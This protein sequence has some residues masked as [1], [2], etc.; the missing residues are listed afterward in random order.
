MGPPKLRHKKLNL[1]PNVKMILRKLGEKCY[2]MHADNFFGCSFGSNEC[3]LE[4]TSRDYSVQ[5]PTSG[6]YSQCVVGRPVLKDIRGIGAH[7]KFCSSRQFY[8]SLI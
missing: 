8:L 3:D 2:H 5:V 1:T 4:G 6:P 7:C